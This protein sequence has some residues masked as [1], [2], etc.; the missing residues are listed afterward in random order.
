MKK[1]LCSICCLS[2]NHSKYIEY[3]IESFFKQTYKNIEIIALDDGS[4]D[5]SVEV[6]NKLKN[7][8]PVPF[9]ILTQEN[10]GNVG[11]NFNKIFKHADGEYIVFISLDDA[12]MPDFIEEKI[13]IMKDDEN[14]YFVATTSPEIIDEK[15]DIVKS[16]SHLPIDKETKD[17]TIDYLLHLEYD[18]LGAFYI[19]G[20]LFRQ[21]VLKQVNCFD[22]DI[23]GDDIVLRTKIFRLMKNSK[24]NNFKIIKK[25]GFQYRRHESNLHKN[26]KR[27][28][29]LLAQYYDRYWGEYPVSKAMISH[30][31]TYISYADDKNEVIDFIKSNDYLIRTTIEC[32]QISKT[33]EEIHIKQNKLG[34][35][36]KKISYPIFEINKFINNKTKYRY[37]KIKILGISFTIRKKM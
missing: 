25:S 7:S 1:D 28:S 23:I 20:C 6:L 18:S 21:S 2:Y 9:K 4:T 10:T 37:K 22:E 29:L 12:L 31:T 19:Q 33:F 15:N 27:Q 24:N 35:I 5:N 34:Y 26:T 30:L 16:K 17:I 13:N 3:A 14:I 36:Y 8:S 32:P 11:A